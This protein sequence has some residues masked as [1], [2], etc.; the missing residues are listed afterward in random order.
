MK[1]QERA[2]WAKKDI[3]SIDEV[4]AREL[5]GADPTN[6]PGS[7]YNPQ[8]STEATAELLA[9]LIYL[10][11]ENGKLT[12]EEVLDLFFNKYDEVD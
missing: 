12:S 4:V 1:L 5:S 6:E 3:Y 10:L 8:Q 11:H 7:E 9:R 2:S